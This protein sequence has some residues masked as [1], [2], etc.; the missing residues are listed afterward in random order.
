MKGVQQTFLEIEN[1]VAWAKATPELVAAIKAAPF[2]VVDVETTGLTPGS[3]PLQLSAPEIRYGADASL[4]L[5][6]LTVA[7]L[8]NGVQRVEAFDLDRVKQEHAQKLCESPEALCDAALTG[9][10]IAHNAGFDLYWCRNAQGAH[11]T[12]P[13]LV[14]DTMLL[15]RI[16]RPDVPLML[17][18]M[19]AKVDD[20]RG[21][22]DIYERAAYDSV[23]QG[24]SGWSLADVSLALL[25]R[26][27][28]KDLQGPR[29]WTVAHLDMDEAHY[30]YATG[31]VYQTWDLFHML[32]GASGCDD[33]MAKF[34]KLRE[35]SSVIE[36]M[37]PQVMELVLM[38]ERGMPTDIEHAREYAKSKRVEARQ[39]ADTLVEV[40]PELASFKAMFA[41]PTKGLSAESKMALAA[42]FEAR[43]VRLGKTDATG[44]PMVGEKDLRLVQAPVI[45]E[46]KPLFDAWVGLS[47][48]KKVSGM[49]L[50]VAAC[51]ERSSDKRVHSLIGHGPV[52]GRLSSQDVNTQQFPRDQKFRDICRAPQGKQIASNDYGAL[53]MRVGS[54]LAVRAQREIREVYLGLSDREIPD[55]L[56][57]A[58][59]FG[60][61][62]SYER[63]M[64][65][66]RERTAALT[67]D[68][69][70]MSAKVDDGSLSKKVYW[71]LRR[72]VS[73]KLLL[74]RFTL[75]LL[76]CRS[77][78]ERNGEAEYSALRDAFR[79]GVDI[80]TYTAI[81]MIGLDAKAEFVGLS[82]A[83]LKE[84]QED[85]KTKL[86]KHPD[87]DKRQHGKVANLSLLYAM[88]ALGLQ[89]TAGKVYGV[90]WSLEQSSE[91]LSQWLNAYPEVDLWHL[92][93]E[94][95]PYAEIWG[96]DPDTRRRTRMQVYESVTLEGRKILAFGLNAALSYQDQS[97]GADILARVMHELRTQHPKL[98]NSVFNQVH[99]EVLVELDTETAE[100]DNAQFV[101]VMNRCAEDLLMPYGVPS[102]VG[103]AVGDV[104]I[105]D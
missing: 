99:D 80:H 8:E 30:A 71:D 82:G 66:V 75:R 15:A 85:W 3:A 50:E 7:W 24:R 17:Q 10:F 11:K 39:W 51:A 97:T 72:K 98:F 26:I 63:V 67:A 90:Y 4:R 105:K 57:E 40:A 36:R 43:G 73:R 100:Q 81:G 9:T 25:E 55:D 59:Q 83:E 2:K 58:I 104:W 65:K 46:A 5:R 6:V 27:L 31:D 45:P 87:G 44:V 89:R 88:K 42:A 96:V 21:T 29:N 18:E 13:D 69:E 77:K 32:V 53:D 93:T 35:E 52:T 84:K 64:P 76:E 61:T 20:S 12:E 56:Q 34:Q 103:P 54:A 92:W 28:P 23:V 19:A 47:K 101:E 78:A 86:K 48:A 102:S 22:G 74:A 16:L 94:L 37:I 91:I 49:A 41:N 70:S 60:M 79:M 1:P 38:R 95:N 62:R 14:L 33:V 68:L